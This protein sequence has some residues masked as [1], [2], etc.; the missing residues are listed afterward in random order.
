METVRDVHAANLEVIMDHRFDD[1]GRHCWK[2]L[3]VVCT[4]VVVCDSLT[5]QPSIH[6]SK[7]F[8]YEQEQ[9]EA[10]TGSDNPDAGFTDSGTDLDAGV[11]DIG[12]EDDAELTDDQG[13]GTDVDMAIDGGGLSDSGVSDYG[14]VDAEPEAPSVCRRF[15]SSNLRFGPWSLKTVAPTVITKVAW[16][17]I[18]H[19]MWISFWRTRPI[20][21]DLKQPQTCMQ[22][23]SAHCRSSV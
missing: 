6:W 21:A 2:R 23:I 13:A 16:R 8:A 14:Y 9:S 18:I 1:S 12:V 19:R 7:D 10:R 5:I 3:R 20:L 22:P 15:R 4:T 17:I 11:S